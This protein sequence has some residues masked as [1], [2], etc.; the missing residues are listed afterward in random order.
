[1]RDIKITEEQQLQWLRDSLYESAILGIC[2]ECGCDNTME[3]DAETCYCY[4][5]REVTKHHGLRS[6]GWI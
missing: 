2:S 5:C 1:M 4:E 3:P 6:M